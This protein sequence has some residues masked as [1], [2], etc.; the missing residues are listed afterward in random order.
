[1]S[2][3]NFTGISLQ[4]TTGEMPDVSHT[5]TS[6]QVIGREDLPVVLIQLTNNDLNV[7]K[8]RAIAR[9]NDS[10]FITLA[11]GTVFD[12]SQRPV[13]PILSRVNALGVSGY[14]PD[15]TPPSLL[16]FSLDLTDNLLILTFNESVAS[17]TL[18]ITQITITSGV[19]VTEEDLSYTL[20]SSSTMQILNL[21]ELV[22]M[23]TDADVNEIKRRDQLATSLTDTYIF[24]IRDAIED[25]FGNRVVEVAPDIAIMSSDYEVDTI[26]PDLMGFNFDANTGEL[27]LTFTETV[28]S[29][30]LDTT[31]ITLF[32]GIPSIQSYTLSNNYVMVSPPFNVITILLTNDDLN[33]IKIMDMLAIDNETL[34]LRLDA[35]TISDMDSNPLRRSRLL[36][37]GIF[38]PDI[39]PPQLLN[40]TIDMNRGELILTFDETVNSSSLIFDFLALIN[41]ETFMPI[42]IDPDNQHQLRGG[43]VL[44]DNQPELVF[45]F[46]EE[47]L[48]EIKRQD[49][50]T[51]ALGILD[52]FLVYRSNA[53]RD[54]SGN[55]IDGCRQVDT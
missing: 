5:L 10:V 55:G 50:C 44:T 24:L 53:V 32:D 21:P 16:E 17:N 54:M 15:F 31:G 9:E 28:N 30:S 11:N 6:G 12:V 42:P 1:M 36:P 38:T 33:E 13:N 29:S 35:G 25:T 3:F 39:T 26:E 14:T 22:I 43:T 47:D 19:N 48:N 45:Q 7:L 40:F 49:M 46:T 8:T 51:R 18:N 2:T 27:I 52:C 37:V 23:L 4:A 41:N 34:Y 20:Q